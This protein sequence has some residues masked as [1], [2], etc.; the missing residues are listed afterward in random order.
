MSNA[1][2][3]HMGRANKYMSIVLLMFE[4][5]TQQQPTVRALDTTEKLAIKV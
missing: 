2:F 5:T 3:E 4:K 1:L